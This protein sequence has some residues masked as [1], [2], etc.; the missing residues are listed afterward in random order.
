MKYWNLL[1]AQNLQCSVNM[2]VNWSL[3]QHCECTQMFCHTARAWWP[4]WCLMQHHE[5]YYLYDMSTYKYMTTCRSRGS[6]R[7][8]SEAAGNQWPAVCFVG[9]QLWVAHNVHS[10]S[11]HQLI[12]LVSVPLPAC[13]QA[14]AADCISVGLPLYIRQCFQDMQV[15]KCRTSRETLKAVVN[16]QA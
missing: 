2:M 10:I 14:L 5:Q 8:H 3:M 7:R 12:V 9:A 16:A 4:V 11:C 6:H 13:K 15:P 1:H